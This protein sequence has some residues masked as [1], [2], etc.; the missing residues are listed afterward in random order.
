MGDD[1]IIATW[2]ERL[3]REA[4]DLPPERA[5]RFVYELYFTAQRALDKKGWEADFER[6]E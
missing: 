3:L 4:P 2:T 1:E 6:E 5:R